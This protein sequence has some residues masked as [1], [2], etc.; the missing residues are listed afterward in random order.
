MFAS[1][2]LVSYPIAARLNITKTEP[3]VVSIGGT[4]IT[5]VTVLLLL[6]I[7]T[8]GY[9]GSLNIFFWIKTIAL[10]LGFMF[11]MLWV[12]PKISRWYFAHFQSDDSAQFIFVLC[13]LFASG[14]LAELAGIEPI[15]GA[16]LC[17]LA[18]N[19]VIPH[20]SSLM[21]RTVFV[22]N[23]LFVPFFMIHIGMLVDL[24]AFFDGA[25]TLFLAVILIVVALATK[26]LAAFATQLLYK[27][28][29]PERTLLFGLSSSRAAATIAVTLIGFKM[30][31]F[32]SH[33][34]NAA[35]LIILITCLVSTYYTDLAGRK[36]ASHQQDQE[37]HDSKSDRILVAMSNPN[38]ALPLFDFSILIHQAHESSI[39]YPLSIVTEPTQMNQSIL[40]DKTF[41][42]SFTNQARVASVRYHPAIRVDNNISEGII[43][44]SLELQSTHIVIGWSGLSGTARYLFGTIMEHLLDNC[45]Q[46]VLITQLVTH[47]LKFRKV[48]VLVPR[49]A[50]H[51]IGFHAW[52]TILQKIWHNSAASL[53]FIGDSHTMESIAAVKEMA[54]LS[55]RNYRILDDFP[56]MPTLAGELTEN[57]LFVVISARHNTV[58]FSRKI[59]VMPRAV[60]RY[61]AHTN[62]VILYPEQP[63]M[64]PDNFGVTFGGV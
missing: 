42:E 29:V 26:F 38:T 64:S 39:I 25:E 56:D 46:T 3:V 55:K 16:F 9:S 31:I 59:A 4:I 47:L 58:S 48:Y 13:S 36:V 49:N 57:D 61:F 62:S 35:I 27:Y 63:E 51:E 44:A 41:I 54:E 60:T 50:E 14:F 7:I 1:H 21:N 20:Q 34:L 33:I 24:K 52:L 37:V 53:L 17:G 32:D 40:R 23:S 5:D 22:G 11:L 18:L 15:V 28:T 6:T 43:R 2:T 30:D 8:A 10:F 19:R 45:K 12:F